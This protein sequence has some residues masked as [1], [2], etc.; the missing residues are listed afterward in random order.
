MGDG[1]NKTNDK[2]IRSKENLQSTDKTQLATKHITSLGTQPST[3]QYND[4]LPCADY[5]SEIKQN[6]TNTIPNSNQ[7]TTSD[8]CHGLDNKITDDVHSK[9]LTDLNISTSFTP[10][11]SIAAHTANTRHTHK[12]NTEHAKRL[13]EVAAATDRLSQSVLGATKQRLD[14]VA[15][16][17]RREIFERAQ[18]LKE[19]ATGTNRLDLTAPGGTNPWLDSIAGSTHK[20]AFERAQHLKEIAAAAGR[21][22]PAYLGYNYNNDFIYA[23][24]NALNN[25]INLTI[26]NNLQHIAAETKNKPLNTGHITHLPPIS[27]SQGTLHRD[28]EHTVN[29]LKTKIIEHKNKIKSLHYKLNSEKLNNEKTEEYIN[30]LKNEIIEL[31]KINEQY[32]DTDDI[33]Q[34]SIQTTDSTQNTI[35]ELTKFISLLSSE[36]SFHCYVITVDIRRSTELMLKAKSSMH[37]QQFIVRLCEGLKAIILSNYGVFDKFTGD[38]V[39]AFF[40]N[41]HSGK[42]AGQLAL[43]TAF[44]AHQFFDAHYRK[45]RN[46]FSTILRDVGLGIG[47]DY[48][49]ANLVRINSFTV[50]GHPVVYACRLSSANP[51]E[52]L[53]NQPAYEDIQ[54]KYPGMFNI[55]ETS[56]NIKTDG[57]IVVYKATSNGSELKPM[58]PAWAAEQ[59]AEEQSEEKQADPPSGDAG[60]SQTPQA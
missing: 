45:N 43:K 53:I 40:P 54:S 48:G 30:Q 35:P 52:T 8:P 27:P 1:A 10:D 18:H 12:Q 4:S 33:K 58:I 38:G 39:L 36:E 32:L 13:N 42:D 29:E 57:N 34:L 25:H 50:V 37:F 56:L 11:V 28:L 60:Q 17:A 19:I 51:G 46:C 55:E 2:R 7:E 6:E 26:K 49:E 20:E 44:E 23:A 21:L 3:T 9:A 14:S 47:I 15:E 5:S 31:K 41:F 24:E 16:S 22:D 59:Q